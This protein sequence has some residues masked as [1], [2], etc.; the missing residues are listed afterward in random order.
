MS[1]ILKTQA[2]LK[3]LFG[4]F[5]DDSKD[6]CP[7]IIAPSTHFCLP[8]RARL[9]MPC[10]FCFADIYMSKSNA[11]LSLF[12]D[13]IDLSKNSMA[14]ATRHPVSKSVGNGT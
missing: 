7:C 1:Y 11:L 9:V 13:D 6:F 5:R 12:W 4:F 3:G 8:L 14:C 2:S 10:C